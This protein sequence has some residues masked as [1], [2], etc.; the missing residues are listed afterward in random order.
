M[1]IHGFRV[2]P[3]IPTP[4]IAPPIRAVRTETSSRMK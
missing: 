2:R 3:Y 1:A 4:K